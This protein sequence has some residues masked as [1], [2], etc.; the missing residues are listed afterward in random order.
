M[1]WQS[2]DVLKIAA[3]ALF[4][5]NDGWIVFCLTEGKATL[6]PLRIGRNNGIEAEVLEA[7]VPGDTVI[8]HPNDKIA[9]GSAV[10]GRCPT[11]A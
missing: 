10:I 4:R 11:A 9:E 1:I 7:V 5:Q 3:G 2:D 6:R 8:V